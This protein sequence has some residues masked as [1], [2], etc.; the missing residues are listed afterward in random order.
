MLLANFPELKYPLLAICPFRTYGI[1]DRWL[2]K[3]FRLFPSGVLR[4]RP[5]LVEPVKGRVKADFYASFE[6][7]VHAAERFNAS[8]QERIDELDLPAPDRESLLLKTEKEVTALL[9]RSREEQL[10]LKEATRRHASHPR[11]L[12]DDLKIVG[13]PGKEVQASL[14]AAL[15]DT[16]YVEL[17]NLPRFN[18]VLAKTDDNT[19]G[20]VRSNQKIILLCFREK[21]AKGFGLSA[22][23]HWGRTKAAI[24]SML[25]PR[26]NQL[27]QLASIQKILRDAEARGLRVVVIGEFVLWYEGGSAEWVVKVSGGESSS[28]GGNTVWYKGTI[29]SKNHGRIVVLPY[30]KESGERVQ[31]HTK[32][33]P[34]DGRA[35]PRHPDDY[36]E[37]PFEVL[38]GD[39]MIGLFGELPYE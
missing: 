15:T 39:L 3:A 17:V 9:R 37:L 19:W 11:P 21:I 12:L 2:M 23:D 10:M 38:D 8:M 18:T 32:N 34:N 27:L 22:T 5:H 26:A 33:G 35:I 24:R 14:H 6:E 29:L 25:L 16:P 31:G 30:I 13:L 4:W 20:R 1:D 7:A 36:V 28:E